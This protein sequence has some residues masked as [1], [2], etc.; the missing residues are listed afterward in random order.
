MSRLCTAHFAASRVARGLC[1]DV[2]LL[3]E[4]TF[5]QR[6]AAFL[7]DSHI[8]ERFFLRHV[9]ANDGVAALLTALHDALRALAADDAVF[10]KWQTQRIAAFQQHVVPHVDDWFMSLFHEV[11]EENLKRNPPSD[12]E[13][14]RIALETGVDPDEL[15]DKYR[16]ARLENAAKENPGLFDEL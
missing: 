15:V 14:R 12:D 3:L 9:A 7:E 10:A 5:E 4:D 11:V 13:L 16:E 2:Q 1:A 6:I 8:S